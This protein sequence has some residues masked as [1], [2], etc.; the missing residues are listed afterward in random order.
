MSLTD[1]WRVVE[2][3]LWDASYLDMME[4][5]Y[6]LFDDKAGGEFAFGCITGHIHNRAAA[7]SADFTWQGND[8]MDEASGDGWGPSFKRTDRSPAR[9]ASTMATTQASSPDPGRLLQQPARTRSGFRK[10]STSAFDQEPKSRCCVCLAP[11]TLWLRRCAPWLGTLA[12]AAESRLLAEGCPGRVPVPSASLWPSGALSQPRLAA[13]HPLAASRRPPLIWSGIDPRL[14]WHTGD[15]VR[16][17]GRP[18][19]L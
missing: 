1:K 2:M 10:N 11:D 7:E 6:I 13:R 16:T 9:S 12:T 8:E 14:T 5:A 15:S 19:I 3:E 18:N 17:F 4:P